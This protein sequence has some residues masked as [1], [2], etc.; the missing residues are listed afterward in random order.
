MAVAHAEAAVDGAAAAVAGGGVEADS[1]EA[2]RRGVFESLYQHLRHRVEATPGLAG[3][4]LYAATGNR[5]GR[6]VYR[7]L[8]MSHGHYALYEWLKD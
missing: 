7:R 3:I 4:R 5:R 6:A 1:R 2:R 8:G